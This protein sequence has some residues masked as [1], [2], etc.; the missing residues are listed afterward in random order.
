LVSLADHFESTAN[1]PSRFWSCQAHWA[2]GSRFITSSRPVAA[3]DVQR[4]L[5]AERLTGG[6]NDKP[7]YWDGLRHRMKSQNDDD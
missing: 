6:L 4:F 3:R 1:D 7:C 2:F 5:G